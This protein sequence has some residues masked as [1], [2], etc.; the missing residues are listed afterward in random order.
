MRG[1]VLTAVLGM[2]LGV[3]AGG[4]PAQAEGECQQTGALTRVR[5]MGHGFETSCT[6]GTVSF[7][8]HDG[9]WMLPQSGAKG[10][11]YIT[12][13]VINW[14]IWS[15][16]ALPRSLVCSN[17]VAIFGQEVTTSPADLTDR[18]YWNEVPPDAPTYVPRPPRYEAMGS[19]TTD[20]TGATDIPRSGTA[21]LRLDCGSVGSASWSVPVTVLPASPRD[22]EPGVSINNGDDFTNSPDVKLY[23]GWEAWDID[24]VKVS[25]D[26][27]FAPSKT[28][29]FDLT[30]A[31]PIDWRLVVLGNERIP[32]IVYVRFHHGAGRGGWDVLSSYTD[33]IVLDTVIPQILAVSLEGPAASLAATPRRV[34]VRAK[35]NKSGLASI[36]VSAGKPKKKSKVVKFRKSVPAPRSGRVFVRVRDGAG[37]WSKWRS[38]G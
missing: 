16:A 8:D 36:Q 37:N 34:R 10:H 27:G 31:D 3:A 35:D 6:A 14:Q 23:L 4:Q 24:K 18:S 25:N 7:S 1:M 17:S 32:K 9:V 20:L 21:S 13:G 22:R 2:A 15:D 28:R 19:A 5:L 11:D 38:A 26:G 29:V 12:S 30:S 33:D